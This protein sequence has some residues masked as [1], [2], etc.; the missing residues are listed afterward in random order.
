[1]QQGVRL[2]GDSFRRMVYSSMAERA[3][4]TGIQRLAGAGIDTDRLLR[5]L[6]MNLSSSLRWPV[7]ANLS[8]IARAAVELEDQTRL[9]EQ[10]QARSQDPTLDDL[11]RLNAAITLGMIL[12]RESC[13]GDEDT[14]AWSGAQTHMRSLEL[15]PVAQR[16]LQAQSEK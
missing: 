16:W 14:C 10:L 11:N 6:T 1:M 7:R 9:A 4:G 3:N 15:P 2:L 5:G 8:R 12:R 13:R